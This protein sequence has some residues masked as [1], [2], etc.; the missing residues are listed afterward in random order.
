MPFYKPSA[1][2][3]SKQKFSMILY[4]A[5][6]T[7]KTTLACSAPKPLLIDFDNGARRI[8]AQ[9]RPDAFLP[10]N[11]DELLQNFTEET[12]K[13]Y[14]TL[15][16]DTGGAL[17]SSMQDYVMRKDPINKTKSGTI[18]QKGYGAVKQEFQNLTNRFKTVYNKNIIYVFH[19]VEE[20]NK[21]GIAMQRLLCEGSSKNIVWQP[22]DFGAYIYMNGDERMAGFTPTDEYFAKGC[23]GI[24]GTRKIPALGANDRNDYLTQLFTEA[25]ANIA[26]DNEYFAAERAAYEAAM[27]EGKDLIGSLETPSDFDEAGE[28]LKTIKHSLTSLAELR[29]FFRDRVKEKGYIFNREKKV[30]EVPAEVPKA[31]S[32]SAQP[33]EVQGQQ[34]PHTAEAPKSPETAAEPTTEAQ[35]TELPINALRSQNAAYEALK[36]PEPK[37][38]Q[39]GEKVFEDV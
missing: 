28:K 12:L 4:G 38:E 6:G 30:Y 32:Q 17:I 11:Y 22:C 29:Q 34:Q 18:S 21:D 2:V 7:G 26:K 39:S 27:Q 5:P 33:A 31:V 37:Q 24:G 23:Y 10:D 25:N 8:R 35:Q 16:I 9:H 14:E 15:I 20:K 3:F 19:S 13:D 36:N 1:E